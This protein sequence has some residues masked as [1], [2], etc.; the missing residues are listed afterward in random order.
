MSQR[1]SADKEDQTDGPPVARPLVPRS[2]RK[3]PANINGRNA[4]KFTVLFGLV[5]H[6]PV[7]VPS[8]AGVLAHRRSQSSPRRWAFRLKSPCALREATRR[9]FKGSRAVR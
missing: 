7:R 4:V 8:Q 5:T 1:S 3:G 6:L 2:E 9:A